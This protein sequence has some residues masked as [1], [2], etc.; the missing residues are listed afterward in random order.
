MA[1]DLGH[2]KKKLKLKH[3]LGEKWARAQGYDILDG[4]P[5]A[6]AAGFDRAKALMLDYVMR[7]LDR[8]TD[9]PMSEDE[10]AEWRERLLN[11]KT[12]HS[13]IMGT[14]GENW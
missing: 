2:G 14:I 12:P 4:H 13:R 3:K 5:E 8:R 11:P 7:F 10:E 1:V 6:Y 9:P